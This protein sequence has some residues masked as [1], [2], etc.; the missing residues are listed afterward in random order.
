MNDIRKMLKLVFLDGQNCSTG[1]TT[2]T[3]HPD[4][5]V[6]DRPVIHHVP[7]ARYNIQPY[8]TTDLLMGW[9]DR[10][11]DIQTGPKNV[12]RQIKMIPPRVSRVKLDD[13]TFAD[14]SDAEVARVQ[15]LVDKLW[16]ETPTVAPACESYRIIL[17]GIHNRYLPQPRPPARRA[18]APFIVRHGKRSYVVD[19]RGWE[20]VT[21]IMCPVC[22]TGV[23]RWHEAGYVPG[24]RKCDG[25][26]REFLATVQA[27]G[28]PAPEGKS[29][30]K[31]Q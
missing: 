28:S 8:D 7:P 4:I 12:L 15:A 23:V 17:Q 3:H 20:A 2:A 5:E 27:L 25:C 18:K 30:L 6:E 16:R 26:R 22:L 9:A 11:S 21:N 29:L 31:V 24:Y 14:V 1:R 19:G 10:E 13:G